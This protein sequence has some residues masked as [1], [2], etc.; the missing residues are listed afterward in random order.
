[1]ADHHEE[2]CAGCGVEVGPGDVVRL[3]CG[4]GYHPICHDPPP[5][6]PPSEVE[7]FWASCLSLGECRDETLSDCFDAAKYLDRRGLLW[8]VRDMVRVMPRHH[9]C[10]PWAR[11]GGR[12]W[13]QT[14]HLLIVPVYDHA[15]RMRLVRGWRWQ[16]DDSPKRL[17]AWG[18]SVKGL[19]MA[20]G[21]G[22]EMLRGELPEWYVS[23]E[24][25]IEEGEPDTLAATVRWPDRCVL[26]IA[27]GCWCQ[28]LAGRIPGG[29]SV[30]IRTDPDE[31]GNRYAEQ[32]G[33]TLKGRC[34]IE[35]ALRRHV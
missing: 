30:V 3:T 15:G 32:I 31:A 23:P 2:R 18:L 27:P 20:A 12:S 19:V 28:E 29:S 10:P 34:R 16:D 9:R 5:R 4:A 7:N 35:R 13:Q 17:A 26:G 33:E 24:V 8:G 14:G 22:L 21:R 6:P 11:Y 1:V 25:V